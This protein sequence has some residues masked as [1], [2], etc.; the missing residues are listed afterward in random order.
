MSLCLII[1][2]LYS[3]HSFRFTKYFYIFTQNKILDWHSFFKISFERSHTMSP[4][5]HN[6]CWEVCCQTYSWFFEATVCYSLWILKFFSFLFGFL[7]VIWF[8]KTSR[9][10]QKYDLPVIICSVFSFF[11]FS[12]LNLQVDVFCQFWKILSPFS[13]PFSLFSPS[14]LQ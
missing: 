5:F 13:A 14:V 10:F 11:P 1:I 6:F 12:F 4:C 3:H 8:S 7:K 9:S 2:V